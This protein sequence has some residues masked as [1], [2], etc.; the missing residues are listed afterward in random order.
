MNKADPF[1]R[2][3]TFCSSLVLLVILT[4]FFAYAWF[5]GYCKE[6]H[7][8]FTGLGNWLLIGAYG[9]L[10]CIFVKIYGGYRVGHFRYSEVIFSLLLSMFLT[11]ALAYVQLCVLDR[12]LLSVGPMVLVM[13]ADIP[14]IFLW[15]IVTGKIYHHFYPPRYMI[16]VYG[17]S[18]AKDLFYKMSQRSDKYRIDA[19]VDV[20][21]GLETVYEKILNYQTVVLCEVE[22]PL[23]NE[24]LKFCYQHDIRTYVSP[25]LTDIILRGANPVLLFDS[26]LLLCRNYHLT[27]EQR[28]IKRCVDIVI[29]LVGI[30]LSSPFMLLA[31]ILV[32]SYDGGPVF[33]RQKRC[34]I[35]GKVFEICKFRSMIVDAEKEGISIPASDHDARITPVGRFIRATR[36]DELPQLFNILKGDMSIV[37]PRPE[38]IEHVEKYSKEVPE[39]SYRLK[40]KGGLTGFAQIYGKYN[41]SPL[42]KLKL[43]LMYIENYSLLLD[44]K[45]MFMTLKVMFMKESTE[46]FP[47][48]SASQENLLIKHK[49]PQDKHSDSNTP[50]G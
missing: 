7:F 31:A 34:T 15:T 19:A 6:I 45:L 9:L 41:T 20:N 16:M 40:V 27:I 38:R 18:S 10:Q 5:Y 11:N 46:G 35:N 50:Q 37:G 12:Q 36:L 44:F 47:Q 25:K 2:L 48:S 43:D 49:Q 29:S 28:I 1:K 39:F 32:K 42:D 30:I 17:Q 23:R 26:P 14:V 33:F 13:L 4:G 22:S 24:V 3:W 8:P 21:E